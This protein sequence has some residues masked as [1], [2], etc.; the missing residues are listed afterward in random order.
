MVEKVLA[1]VLRKTFHNT[2]NGVR[3][4]G[5]NFVEQVMLDL[6]LK[7]V[8]RETLFAHIAKFVDTDE[9]SEGLSKRELTSSC[10]M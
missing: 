6:L 9:A 5:H 3:S 2:Q 4:E 1:E 10:F 8:I 7:H